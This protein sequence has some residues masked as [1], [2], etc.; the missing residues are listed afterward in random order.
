V[1]AEC[2]LVDIMAAQ[3]PNTTHPVTFMRG[4]THIDYVLATMR[5][6]AAV[7]FCGYEEFQHRVHSD[8]RAY[9]V[10]FDTNALLVNPFKILKSMQLEVCIPTT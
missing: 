2:Q 8:H 3:H 7:R 9:Y 6:A 4:R 10:D 5:V 1:A